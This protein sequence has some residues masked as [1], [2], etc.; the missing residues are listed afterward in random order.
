M[1]L[2]SEYDLVGE[3]RPELCVGF[4]IVSAA[5]SSALPSI[6][7]PMIVLLLSFVW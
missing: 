1:D 2:R 7:N 4:Y 6:W 5:R 3:I